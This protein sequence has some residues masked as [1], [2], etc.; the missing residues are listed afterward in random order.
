MAKK[1]RSGS[2]VPV[3]LPSVALTTSAG[4][5]EFAADAG[6]GLE[7]A[8]A[9]SFAIPFLMVLQ[10]GSPQVDPSSGDYIKGAEPGMLYENI[11]RTL[12]DSKTGVV[13]V[14]CAYRRVFLRWTQMGFAGELSAE[15]VATMRAAG[16]IAEYK[17]RLYVP[18]ADGTV[19]PAECDRIVDTRNHYVLIVD[20]ETGAWRQA[21]ISLSSTQIKKSRALNVAL[22]MR[23]VAVDDRLV[24]PATFANL[25]RVTTVPESNDKGSWMGWH[26]ELMGFVTNHDLYAAARA[27]HGAVIGGR[28]ES[29]RYT[30]TNNAPTAAD[31][32]MTDDQ[33]F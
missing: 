10:K 27:F 33:S 7:G 2:A 23:K 32:A 5:K 14:P 12:A 4:M 24:T 19:D 6:A 9:E 17:N 18:A 28:T 21:L 25:V 30:Q 31:R 1:N 22:V 8:G 20:E 26:F 3:K 15:D 29:P 11:S 16:G 13:A